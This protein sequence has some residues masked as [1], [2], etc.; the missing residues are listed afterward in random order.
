MKT[1]KTNNNILRKGIIS[2]PLSSIDWILFIVITGFCFLTFQQ[3]DI[4]HTGGSSFA[5]LNGHILDFYEYNV[6]YV[7]GNSY[8]P[9]TY[10]LFAIWNIPI[11]L[12]KIVTLPTC[13]V[14]WAVTMWYKALPVL[15]YVLSGFV[16]YKICKII[17]FGEKKSKIIAY[18]FLTSPIAVFS[19]FIFGQYD[20]FTV[21][22]I[23]CGMYFYFK[24]DLLNF[25]ILFGVAITFKYFA[26]LI[27]VPLLLL[28][29]KDILKIIKSCTICSIPFLLEVLGY[30]WSPAFR[31]GVLGFGAKNYIF[32]AGFNTSTTSISIVIV[33]WI[34]VVVWAYFVDVKTK[35]ELI[36]WAFYLC[37]IVIFLI[38]GLSTWHPQWLLFAI[39]FMVMGTAI[40]RKF[41][42]FIFIDI[43]IMVFF[44]VFTIITWPNHVDQT[45]MRQ[46]IFKNLLDERF[47]LFVTMRSIFHISDPQLMLSG[48]SGLLLAGA[49]FKHPKFS[50]DDFSYFKNESWNLVRTRFVLGI[51]IWVIPSLICMLTSFYSPHV[52]LNNAN[53]VDGIV[54]PLSNGKVIEQYFVPTKNEISGIQFVAGTYQRINNSNVNFSIQDVD[55]NEVWSHSETASKF[56]DNII[57]TLRFSKINVNRDKEYKIVITASDTDANNEITLYHTSVGTVTE[58][59]YATIDGQKV[60]YNL[61]L[62]ILV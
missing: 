5:Y 7:G 28:K 52:I 45:L 25:I 55:G 26:F 4:Y 10:I 33:L 50:L 53:D 13:S 40:S 29:E 23:L 39:P 47:G 16:V 54:G 58:V 34:A 41:D 49:L 35:V 9:S 24:N 20:V 38:F 51:S 36:S 42:F 14:P 22:F 1:T 48:M 12:L 31:N 15:F 11:Y 2:S 57:T 62:N 18:I 59:E 17:S 44:T 56:R 3:M 61:S 27:F 32:V 46:G 37:N 19:Q 21:F 60:D 43:L 30:Y 8:L 6:K